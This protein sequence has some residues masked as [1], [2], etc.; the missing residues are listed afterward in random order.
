MT[1]DRIGHVTFFIEM[2]TDRSFAGIT[3]FFNGNGFTVVEVSHRGMVRLCFAFAKS[4]EV[5]IA[6]LNGNDFFPAVF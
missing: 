2:Q 5:G 4:V 3:F 6:L 1:N